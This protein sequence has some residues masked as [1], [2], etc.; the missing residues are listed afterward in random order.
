[1][2]IEE[3]KVYFGEKFVTPY[4]EFFNEETSKWT[5]G[6]STRISKPKLHKKYWHKYNMYETE[7]VKQF[8][9]PCGWVLG[10]VVFRRHGIAFMRWEGSKDKNFEIDVTDGSPFARHLIPAVI[11]KKEFPKFNYDM[12]FIFKDM[13]GKVTIE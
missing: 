6:V 13:D 11:S 4:L 8:G 5:T 2:T 3:A 10:T 7:F 12:A 9:K 1:M